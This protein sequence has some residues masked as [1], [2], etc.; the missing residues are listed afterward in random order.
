MVARRKS[1]NEKIVES[2]QSK[3]KGQRSDAEE[4]EEEAEDRL[5]SVKG[6]TA[7]PGKEPMKGE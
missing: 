2:E 3:T 6:K 7:S 5:I 4:T 1:E